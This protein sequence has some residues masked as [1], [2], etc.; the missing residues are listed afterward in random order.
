MS[1]QFDVI[2]VGGGA[3]GM[4][5]AGRAA[6]RGLSVLLLEKNKRLGMKLAITGGGRCNIC[7]AE[8]DIHRLLAHYGSAKK[9][10]YSSF[11]QFG[12]AETFTFFTSRGLPLKVEAHK[13]AFPVTEQA[14]DVVRVLEKYM[15]QGKVTVRTGAQVKGCVAEGGKIVGV[16]VSG[17]RLSAR[18]Y[19]LATGGKSHPETGSTGDGFRWLADLRHTVKEPTPSV[20]PLAVSDA[21]VK[22]LAGVALD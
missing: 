4:M 13:R 8:E 22:S 5:A 10:L 2:V 3:S 15:R 6:E 14:G 21:W 7:N 20:V 19:I 17:T 11:S 12:V 9:F 16:D 1:T 18:A